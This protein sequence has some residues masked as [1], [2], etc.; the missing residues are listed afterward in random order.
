M[1]V[2]ESAL[3]ARAP[4]S[5]E[6]EL[7]DHAGRIDELFFGEAPARFVVSLAR[8]RV[9]DARQVA[10]DLGAPFMVIG[11]TVEADSAERA[12]LRAA[13]GAID[14]RRVALSLADA[15]R[16]YESGFEKVLSRGP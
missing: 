9:D 11:Q 3:A 12:T 16:A 15:R 2:A 13:I 6:L 14:D 5:V 7:G 1:A 10:A 4:M 8:D